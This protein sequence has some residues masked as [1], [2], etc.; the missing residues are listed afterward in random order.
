M[1]GGTRF[2]RDLPEQAAAEGIPK[3]FPVVEAGRAREP[4]VNGSLIRMHELVHGERIGVDNPLVAQIIPDRVEG[5]AIHLL[6]NEVVVEPIEQDVEPH[7][8]LRRNEIALAR[9]GYSE[10]FL[11]PWIGVGLRG[12]R[13]GTNR[14]SRCP[15]FA[16]ESIVRAGRAVVAGQVQ[17]EAGTKSA[18]FASACVGKADARC[19]ERKR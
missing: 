9:L 6:V 11:F 2:A 15:N 7:D 4:E 17:V 19:D 16:Q 1:E 8:F 12:R 3:G 10:S 14:A 13:P 5:G 18:S